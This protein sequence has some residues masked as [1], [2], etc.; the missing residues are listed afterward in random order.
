MFTD[1]SELTKMNRE[2]TEHQHGITA[3]NGDVNAKPDEAF[4]VRGDAAS[5]PVAP[6]RRR[7]RKPRGGNEVFAGDEDTGAPL[8]KIT[9]SPKREST[10]SHK[11][12]PLTLRPLVV[13]SPMTYA[14]ITRK[15]RAK[16]PAI[17]GLQDKNKSDLDLATANSSG[18]LNGF[19]KQKPSRR[20]KVKVTVKSHP[21]RFHRIANAGLVAQNRNSSNIAGGAKPQ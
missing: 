17:D 4:L 5:E 2:L 13:T 21:H 14:E 12:T 10:L 20:K 7:A 16:P 19:V 6:R 1:V 15:K 3:K 18:D 9:S 11:P 8:L